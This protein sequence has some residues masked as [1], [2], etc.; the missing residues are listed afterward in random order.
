MVIGQ[1]YVK[2]L[3]DTHNLIL[4]LLEKV[5]VAQARHQSDANDIAISFIRS[6]NGDLLLGIE[7]A[8]LSNKNV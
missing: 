5:V 7:N 4:A 3:A 6:T 8:Q 1:D 2:P